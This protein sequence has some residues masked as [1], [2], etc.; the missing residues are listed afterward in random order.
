MRASGT[1]TLGFETL[2]A[3]LPKLR[4][5]SL[6]NPTYDKRMPIQMKRASSRSFGIG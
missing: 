6:R 4:R 5:P 3:T 1:A 2:E